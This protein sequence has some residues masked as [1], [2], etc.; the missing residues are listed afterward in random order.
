MNKLFIFEIGTTL[1]Q[2]V[3]II[4][5]ALSISNMQIASKF[6]KEGF[7]DEGDIYDKRGTLIFVAFVI[8][9]LIFGGL[10]YF[11]VHQ[12]VFDDVITGERIIALVVLLVVISIA[13]MITYLTTNVNEKEIEAGKEKLREKARKILEETEEEKSE[14][15][16]VQED[17]VNKEVMQELER[18]KAYEESVKKAR[19]HKENAD[20]KKAIAQAEMETEWEEKERKE[21]EQ[22]RQEEYMQMIMKQKE[23]EDRK[24]KEAAE[25]E[26][27]N[28]LE[29]EA[30]RQYQAEQEER[31]RE[32][33]LK[34]QWEAMVK[35]R[36]ERENRER[37]YANSPIG[38]MSDIATA[39]IF[40]QN[41]QPL[42]MMNTSPA[43]TPQR[44]RETPD[45]S[46]FFDNTVQMS[47]DEIEAADAALME[48]P[49]F[50]PPVTPQHKKVPTRSGTL[51]TKDAD[52]KSVKDNLL[53]EYI[54]ADGFTSNEAY[55]WFE[56]IIENEDLTIQRIIL[57]N[58]D[59]GEIEELGTMTSAKELYTFCEKQGFGVITIVLKYMGQPVVCGYKVKENIPFV[60]IKQTANIEYREL[61]EVLKIKN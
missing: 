5:W 41:T 4:L 56:K 8:C 26:K 9:T 22:R 49:V 61:E 12:K 15:E 46:K 44:N 24:A 1:F 23:E 18:Q 35:A 2:L 50:T 25:L 57:K 45:F 54:P 32:E 16:K 27:R 53:I 58:L 10:F 28:R 55:K 21:E 19:E 39:S 29:E 38:T 52:I 14:T 6:Y 31:K 47:Q 33:E 17:A 40:E 11:V 48:N 13:M 7:E 42:P 43:P 51:R 20:M 37:A 59:T 30:R 34:A 60:S 36:E 3:I